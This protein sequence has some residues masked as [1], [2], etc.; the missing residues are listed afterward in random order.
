LN[1]F[2]VCQ[3]LQKML[4]AIA[5]VSSSLAFVRPVYCFLKISLFP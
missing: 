2:F 3:G 1:S 4:S 5:A